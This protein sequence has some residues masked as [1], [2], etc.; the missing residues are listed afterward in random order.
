MKFDII[1]IVFQWLTYIVDYYINS[2][3]IKT[4]IKGKKMY[5]FVQKEVSS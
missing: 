3:H 1:L 2:E 5:K 4:I